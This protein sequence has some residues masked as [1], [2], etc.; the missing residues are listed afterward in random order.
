MKSET[1]RVRTPRPPHYP[2]P[3][4]LSARRL[5]LLRE[6]ITDSIL[7]ASG[8]GDDELL[9]E[10]VRTAVHTFVDSNANVE[11]AAGSVA[12][13]MEQIGARQARRG[14][15][16]ADLAA[17]FRT[18]LVATQ[19]GLPLVVGDLVTRDTMVQLRED[20]VAYLTELQ[21]H[22]HAGLVRAR[23]HRATPLEQRSVP[24]A[25]LDD[26]DPQT[27]LRAIVSLTTEIPIALR[28]HPRTVT[29]PSPYEILIPQSW[30]VIQVTDDFIGQAV[31]GPTVTAAQATEALTLARQAA[32]LLRDGTI[33]DG[34]HVIDCTDLLGTLIVHANP[35]L[36]DLMIG[37]H[38]A[39][40]HAMSPP[41]RVA[42]GELLLTTLESGQTLAAD[43]RDL[44]I[45][46]QT[47]HSRMKTLRTTFGATLDDPEQRLELT[48]ALRAALPRWRMDLTSPQRKLAN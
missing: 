23:R 3:D 40:L 44:G 25:G 29:S 35:L 37:K 10:I 4:E 24:L 11:R 19:K 16:A 12:D 2:S 45:S 5:D 21:I 15:N 38:L 41:R 47:A 36:A 17:S 13:L 18:A 8:G 27:P 31:V 43:A 46:R 9:G 39:A 28:D 7:Q 42:L 48:V 6:R 34:R 22:A 33:V 14:F 32:G 30:D 20:L 1:Q 26:L